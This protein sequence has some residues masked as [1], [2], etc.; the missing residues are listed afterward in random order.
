MARLK[1][2]MCLTECQIFVDVNGI[3]R[4]KRYRFG[5][6]LDADDR[7]NHHFIEVDERDRDLEPRDILLQ[8][9]SDIGIKV[10]DDWAD[11]VLQR[12]YLS[13]L[14]SKKK[15]T[16][17]DELRSKAKEIGAKVYFGWKDPRKYL[18]AIETR[19]IE[20]SAEA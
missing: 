1:R 12:I 3:Q 20:L 7:P 19:E 5:E 6:P 2:Y 9:L 18:K 8:L 14:H 17:L 11:D 15:E 10:Q 4:P 13:H 16:N